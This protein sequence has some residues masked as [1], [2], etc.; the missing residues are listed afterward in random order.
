M[1]LHR[2]S[3]EKGWSHNMMMKMSKRLFYRYYG[4]YYQDTLREKDY[5]DEMERKRKLEVEQQSK[6]R[7]WK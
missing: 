1:M 7:N 4:Y 5:H 6:P 3:T 2:L